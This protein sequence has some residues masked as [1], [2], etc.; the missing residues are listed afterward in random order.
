[1]RPLFMLLL[2]W[3]VAIF[4]APRTPAAE[5]PW[6]R[7]TIDASSRGADG[8]RLADVNGDGRPD[9]ATGWE[10]GGLVRVC[11]HPG[12]QRVRELWPAVT[13]GK[14]RSPEDAVFADLDNDGAVDVVSCCEGHTRTVFIHWAPRDQDRYLRAD[15]WHTQPVP[16][17]QGQQLWMFAVPLN[18][19]ARHGVDLIVGSKGPDGSIGWLQ[20]PANPRALAD[21]K[22]HRLRDSGW[23]MSLITRDMDG[24]GDADVVAS[25]RKGPSRRVLWLENPGPAAAVEGNRWR[26]HTVGGQDFETMFLDLP[27]SGPNDS[28]PRSILAAVKPAMILQFTRTD[29]GAAWTPSRLE[30]SPT[31]SIGTAKSVRR[32][33]IDLDGSPDLVYSCEKAQG[34]REGVFWLTVHNGKIQRHPISGPD[35]VKFDLLQ[36]VDLDS[37]GDP[38][39]ITCEE[40]DNLGLIW[41]ENPNRHP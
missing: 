41:Y 18:V 27:S 6:R 19:D 37:D 25:D 35:G 39:V 34:Q 16:C 31:D 15:A 7:H 26:E 9:I 20:S 17:T 13:V 5:R 22:Y 32:S 29:A 21:W 28:I 4:P 40:R 14:V 38:D 1:M 23:I 24:D 11:L 2:A 12:P 36:L 30:L 33:D 8:A 10:E 3:T